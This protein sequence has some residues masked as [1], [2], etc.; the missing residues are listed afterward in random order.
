MPNHPT[1][2]ILVKL[3]REDLSILHARKGIKT[4]NSTK[5]NHVDTILAAKHT[6]VQAEQKY[7]DLRQQEHAL[8]QKIETYEKRKKT[9]TTA[10][11]TGAGN[12]DSAERQIQQCAQIIDD[13]EFEL[14]ENLDEQEDA[15]IDLQKNE[16]QLVV[17]NT[18]QNAFEQKYDTELTHYRDII[19]TKTSNRTMIIQGLEQF[20][21]KRYE[22]LRKSK[23][24]AVARVVDNCCRTCQLALPVQDSSDVRRAREVSCRK[25]GRWLFIPD[26]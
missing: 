18:E 4:L 3:A 13:S 11:E 20:I 12:P 19:V 7:T 23:G 1:V 6:I 15:R 14:L 8:Q 10:L 22:Q 17:L 24:T 16:Q 9:A 26:A 21:S 5:K 25:C 2:E